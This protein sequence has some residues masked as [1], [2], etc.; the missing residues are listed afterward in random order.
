[1]ARYQRYPIYG[2]QSGKV[3]D[4]APWLAASDAFPVLTNA[5]VDKGVLEKRKGHALLASTGASLPIMG[6]FEARYKGIPYNLVLD[7]KRLYVYDITADTLT[8]LSTANTYTGADYDYFKFCPYYDKTYF[9]NGINGIDSIDFSTGSGVI[10][11]LDTAAGVGTVTIATC[12]GMFMLKDRLHFVAPT[13]GSTFYPDRTYYT[14]VGAT[15]ITNATQYYTYPRDD[16]PVAYHAIDMNNELIVG[17]KGSWRVEYTGD[18]DTPFAC[19]TL[20]P[21]SPC[22]TPHVLV[23]YKSPTAGRLLA[24]L[25]NTH[26]IAFDGNQWRKIDWPIRDLPA[27]M[28][29]RY[30]YYAQGTKAGDRESLYLTYPDSDDTYPTKMLEYNINENNWAEHSLTLHCIRGISGEVNPADYSLTPGMIGRAGQG[31]T[32]GGDST[33]NL[34]LLDSGGDDNGAN[35]TFTA[36]SA[37]LNPFHQQGRKAYL[38]WIDLYMDYDA[39]ASF[40]MNLYKDDGDTAYKTVAISG[41]GAGSR[42]WQRVNVG[43]EIGNFHHIELTNTDA[44]NRPRIHAICPWFAPGGLMA[45]SSSVADWPDQTWRLHVESGVLY[46]Q[47]RESGSWVNFESWGA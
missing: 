29:A 36:K 5:R 28:A 25:S 14:D 3:I 12:R 20:D 37:A 23:E 39:T 38:G 1:V 41:D 27:Q 13:I 45:T 19:K 43:G 2:F 7:T 34:F 11:D 44:D 8:D 6:I 46:S 16:V 31:Y 21:D 15:T 47:R 32:Y 10:T 24:T 35:I 33:G 18:S 22:C 4:K 17:H 9:V 40:T 42:F 30:L 26:I